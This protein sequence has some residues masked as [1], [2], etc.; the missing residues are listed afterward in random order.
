MSSEKL[1]TSDLN[2][3][4]C[5]EYT[6]DKM[7]P[8]D[9]QRCLELFA[10]HQL[11][12][13]VQG[14]ETYRQLDPDG[15]WVARDISTGQILAMCGGTNFDPSLGYI[16]FYATCP[17]HQGKGLGTSVWSRVM[18]HLGQDCNIGLCATPSQAPM[19]RDKAGFRFQSEHSMIYYYAPGN[20][21]P[22]KLSA[23]PVNRVTIKSLDDSMMDKVIDYDQQLIGLNRSQLIRLSVKEE[24][25][26]TLVA[27][28]DSSAQVVGFG[29]IKWSN[30]D[31]A[32]LGPVY[33]DSD[34]IAEL[35]VVELCSK[36]PEIKHKGLNWMT[37]S[38]NE[39]AGKMAAKLGLSPVMLN[40]RLYTKFVPKSPDTSKIY[41]I[42]SPDFSPF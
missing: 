41:A 28:D 4:K 15:Y 11:A 42:F 9:V 2:S 26:H 23:K 21:E 12:E 10:R 40:P 32:I 30:M 37:D 16:G 1:D 22:A 7:R 19:Y 20:I 8:E 3:S 36:Y 39:A 18:Q 35:L 25:A 34:S 24:S 14:L 17:D 31:N 6:V 29:T 13:A 27:L 5:P 33:A 38:S